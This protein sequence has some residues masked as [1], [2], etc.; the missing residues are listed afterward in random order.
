MCT[1][2]VECKIVITAVLTIKSGMSPLMISW[3]LELVW[4]SGLLGFLK[5]GFSRLWVSHGETL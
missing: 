4:L 3:K 2:Y 1:T 5:V